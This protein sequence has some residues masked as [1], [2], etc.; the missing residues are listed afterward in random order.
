MEEKK[1]RRERLKRV[2]KNRAEEIAQ[3][4]K[5]LLGKHEGQ[6]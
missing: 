3:S 4:V 1:G 6:V 5:A 2:K